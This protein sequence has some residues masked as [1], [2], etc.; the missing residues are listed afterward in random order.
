MKISDNIYKTVSRQISCISG[1]VQGLYSVYL[2]VVEC[3][4]LLTYMLIKAIFILSTLVNIPNYW[5][6]KF[7]NIYQKSNFT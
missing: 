1:L 6:S 5:L 2:G 7:L 4:V 3:M